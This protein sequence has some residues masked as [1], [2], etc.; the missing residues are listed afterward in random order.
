[1]ARDV[2][3]LIT[4][5]VMS[6]QPSSRYPSTMYSRKR[7]YATDSCQDPAK[8][9]YTS[10]E[11]RMALS[12]S[13]LR[14]S[15]PP[16]IPYS[17]RHPRSGALIRSSP[18]IASDTLFHSVRE[19]IED[20]S[21]AWDPRYSS[22]GYPERAYTPSKH[23]RFSTHSYPPSS[24]FDVSEYSEDVDHDIPEV[25]S[26]HTSDSAPGRN[27]V[28]FSDIEEEENHGNHGFSFGHGGYRTTFF[29]TS[30][31][32]G[33]WKSHPI[34]FKSTP[35]PQAQRSASIP[36]TP[37]LVNSTRINS[38]PAPS[39]M[40]GLGFSTEPDQYGPLPISIQN[41]AESE[42]QA[43]SPRTMPSLTS[44]WESIPDI[45]VDGHGYERPSSPL[46]PS[47]PMSY[48]VSI[49]S[50]SVSPASSPVMRPSSPLS[51]VSSLDQEEIQ[52]LDLQDVHPDIEV[53]IRSSVIFVSWNLL[54]DFLMN[55]THIFYVGIGCRY[56][57]RECS[58][59]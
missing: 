2:F 12:S 6:S 49:L 36:S 27:S 52:A 30:A 50:R 57:I 48:S 18:E 43:E 47:S 35:L 19:H 54:C 15:S 9:Y 37:V 7:I 32:R 21:W 56:R 14:S 53:K 33:Q 58:R 25:D 26:E 13:P 23:D 39:T 55:F 59:T 24:D 28:S 22:N 51:E 1:M 11:P 44:D 41:L 20:P 46:P 31:E 4:P 40:T 29:R 38:E 45:D 8:T 10:Y 5:T 34:P 42:L 16:G 17:P 3:A